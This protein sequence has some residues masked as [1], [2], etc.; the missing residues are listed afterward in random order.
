MAILM[1]SLNPTTHHDIYVLTAAHQ[2]LPK[3]ITGEGMGDI[4]IDGRGGDG[5]RGW[6]VAA[7]CHDGKI[8]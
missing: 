7:T 8:W 1:S 6:K 5:E 2:I 3:Q 4:A